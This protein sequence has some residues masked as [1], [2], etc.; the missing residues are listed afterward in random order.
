MYWAKMYTSQDKV[1]QEYT[2][3]NKAIQIIITNFKWLPN[4]HFHS[5]FQLMDPEDGTLFTDHVEIRV[6]GLPKLEE[7]ELQEADALEKWL[8]FLK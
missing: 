3:L 6:L 8:L 1:G 7:L 2:A 4:K 5:L